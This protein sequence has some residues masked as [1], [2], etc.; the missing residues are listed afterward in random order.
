VR[1]HITLIGDVT[2]RLAPAP[3]DGDRPVTLAG[4]ERVVLAALVLERAG[5]L[6]RD[7]L[8]DLL[9]PDGL[10]KTWASALR[11]YVSRCR[12]ALVAALGLPAGD[13]F[14]PLVRTG[15]RY[16][17]AMPARVELD[18]DLEQAEAGLA[19]ARRRLAAGQP[20]EA[21]DL[22]GA[23]A[24]AMAGPFLAGWSGRWIDE[25]RGR[26]DEVALGA[27]ELA[28]Q[29]A[30]SAGDPTGALAAADE[31]VARAPLRESAQRARLAALGA[32]GNRAEALRAYQ[33]L[34]RALADEMGVDP[35]PETEAVYLDLLGP[36][37]R[38]P[39]GHPGRLEPAGTATG[40]SAQ[41]PFVGRAAEL[42]VLADAWAQAASGGRHVVMVTGE[43]GIGK[44]RLTAE[45]AR[46]VSRDG[47]LVLFGRCDQ[48]AIVPYQ[49]VVEAL[50]ALVA[51]TP[52]DELP[53][54]GDEA[55]AELAAVLP[56]LD[57]RRRP[58]APWPGGRGRLFG[59]VTDL[60]AAAAKE[61]PLLVVLDDLQ[62]ADDDTLLLVRHL[63]RRAG[64]AAVLVV[65]ISR[66]HDIEPGNRLGDVVHA[67]DR[68][69]WVRRLPLR[70]LDENEVRELVARLRG[71]GPEG[72]DAAGGAEV[73]RL[74]AETAGNPFLLTEL[75]RAGAP[76]GIP[77]GVVDL[78]GTRLA[79]LDPAAIDLL[80][81]GAV[82][83]ARFE[84]D[85]V[86][87]AAGLDR[88]GSAPAPRVEP[89]EGADLYR[90][91][92]DAVLDAVDAALASGLVVEESAE[93]YRF[94]HDILRRT[95][96]AQ[97]SAVRRRALHDRLARAIERLRPDALDEYAAVLAH[98]SSAGAAPGPAGDLRAV[99]WARR[100]AD[101]ATARNAPAEAVRLW[102]QALA[103]LPAGDAG[104]TAEVTT[105]LGVALV[106]A[107]ADNGV[108]TLLDGAAL[109]R[110]EG[111]SDVLGRAALAL[112]EAAEDQPELR[113]EAR[114]LVDE[115]M[116][117]AQPGS[118]DDPGADPLRHAHLLV[119]RV[120]LAADG[121]Q[122]GDAAGPPHP[123][124]SAL[125][126]LRARIAELQAPECVE[127]RLRLA[128]ELAVLADRA[129][130][131]EHRVV[132]AHERAV[133]TATLG[134]ERGAV[135]ALAALAESAAA[136]DP[137]ARAATAECEVARLTAQGAFAEASERLAAAVAAA[138]EAGPAVARRHRTL[139]AW[140]WAD[141]RPDPAAGDDAGA[142]LSLVTSG[143]RARARARLRVLVEDLRRRPEDATTLSE[144][145]LA[146]LAAHEL[147]D[148]PMVAD[149]RALLAPHADLVC[150]LGYRFFAGSAVLH[151]GRAAAAVGEWAEAERHLL[152]ALRLH[153]AWRARPWVALTQEALAAVL[154]ARGRSSDREWIAGLRSE[155][156]WARSHLAL[157]AP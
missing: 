144:L 98:H 60:V 10:P 51:A 31:A 11:T 59:A 96:V 88:H 150:C 26:L 123:P 30:L 83:G 79:S 149:T 91:D 138:G 104:L 58:G 21:R 87:A 64:D 90:D 131:A 128:D 116:A 12:A 145:G 17:V 24:G 86:A 50:D 92:E 136:G 157:R 143:Q 115:A 37:P 39:P 89:A 29:A 84:L 118:P 34:R 3:R 110:A 101:A 146:S 134:D 15:G 36:A 133:A 68:D 9:W 121:E 78:V 75:L 94:P 82:A 16:A 114:R 63:L 28:S 14:D 85:L 71:P 117:A 27:L 66:D 1:L 122:D 140:L 148:A 62:W 142:V 153:T 112:A 127:Q 95:L 107:H 18:V 97:L 129:D 93:R 105:D 125:E 80:R 99:H 65:A 46:R 130:S 38:V 124:R 154:E 48:E 74:V 106:A 111:R 69:G 43:A 8:A 119:S 67:L 72:A 23:A 81:A 152:A 22:A 42:A 47:G 19:E 139:I 70:G 33:R 41:T 120:R 77:A 61:R 141:A 25:V 155:A 40:P 45:A 35:A 126:T 100:A 76:A 54:I 132:A 73:A 137:F 6:D 5:G 53:A 135:D 109:A 7:G 103:H 13:G 56:S 4:P 55:M 113:A 32:T 108:R 151:L 20:G 2:V 156:A 102:R 52:A 44:T 57:D 49:P 147:G